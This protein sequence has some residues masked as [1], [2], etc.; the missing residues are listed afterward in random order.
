MTRNL[1]RTGGTVLVA[2]I[3]TLML[4]SAFAMPAAAATT[5]ATTTV[6]AD[7]VDGSEYTETATINFE[8]TDDDNPS[9]GETVTIQLTKSNVAEGDIEIESAEIDDQSG[10]GGAV[11]GV[12]V[13][14]VRDGNIYTGITDTV[15]VNVTSVSGSDASSDSFDLNVTYTINPQAAENAGAS[16]YAGDSILEITGDTV[17]DTNDN[18]AGN[19]IVDLDIE[20]GAADRLTTSGTSDFTHV[21][22]DTV[23]ITAVD[24]YGAEIV[25]GNINDDDLANA[26]TTYQD[27]TGIEAN[28]TSTPN[29]L[30]DFN[31]TVD[32]N[33]SSDNSG[34]GTYSLQYGSG[35][36]DIDTGN[37]VGNFELQVD[38]DGL[39]SSTADSVTIEPSAVVTTFEKSNYDADA[40]SNETNLSVE[41]TD[42]AGTNLDVA[43]L[44]V[45]LTASVSSAGNYRGGTANGTLSG[46]ALDS[47]QVVDDS[48][49]T[50]VIFTEN[51]NSSTTAFVFESTDAADY[52]ITATEPS[53][54]NSGSDTVTVNPGS[55]HTLDLSANDV[56]FDNGASFDDYTVTVEDA[57]DNQVDETSQ[58]SSSDTG[59]TFTLTNS[60]G[61]TYG[62][63]QGTL[64]GASGSPVTIG[65][66]SD[67]QA[68]VGSF[69][70]EVEQD[71]GQLENDIA[72]DTFTV[73]PAAV[74]IS[75][76]S[77]HDA[78]TNTSL[79][80]ALQ[81]AGTDG[82]V[83][84]VSNFDFDLR[85]NTENLQSGADIAG[86]EDL[87]VEIEDEGQLNA[88]GS[89]QDVTVTATSGTTEVIF[90]S[91]AAGAFQLQA[92]AATESG[93]A[94]DTSAEF[95]VYP[96]AISELSADISEEVIG[97][98]ADDGGNADVTVTLEDE[99]GNAAGY[100]TNAQ[101]TDV[102]ITLD[103]SGTEV[104]TQTISSGNL[105]GT[106]PEDALRTVSL[107]DDASTSALD[108]DSDITDTDVGEAT[109]NVDNADAN[110]V[111]TDSNL[112]IAHETYDLSEGFQRISLPQ[113]AEVATQ[114]VN[115]VTTWNTSAAT[116]DQDEI[117]VLTEQVVAGDTE[118][119][120]GLYVNA[121]NSN[122]RIGF[123][124]ETS[125]Q[126]NVGQE[127]LE[128]GWNLVGTNFDISTQ[129]NIP[130]EEDL[131]TV[132]EISNDPSSSEVVYDGGLAD[133]LDASGT[134]DNTETLDETYG[135]RAGQFGTYWV[136]VEDPSDL[137]SAE[138]QLIGSSYDPDQREDLSP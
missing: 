110:T 56:T 118:L 127:S 16:D 108:P 121:E 104:Y 44:S 72:T 136:Y 64:T 75:G 61:D 35:G 94:T 19:S 119:H 78:D 26:D 80:V 98:Q 68:G 120:S 71:S 123:D 25:P 31:T 125:E 86:S 9:V 23:T 117:D 109:L 8:G 95:D 81:D 59:L 126:V 39:V 29:G 134:G 131:R 48:L 124:F 4:L 87:K 66:S 77:N 7:E 1:K 14:E 18:L 27:I 34:T 106:N 28:L 84:N 43:E 93:S 40:T 99:F 2:L 89:Q 57:Y 111:A 76:A 38:S 20:P 30:E 65:D 6:N 132:D 52:Q 97:A 133:I 112:H 115:H 70:L 67:I 116:Y 83:N 22:T 45:D 79:D 50:S 15:V 91:T 90:N 33:L 82:P 55:A 37:Y 42:G 122:A 41:F 46:G 49:D 32:L 24:Q 129:D 53:G 73:Y 107:G 88:S 51:A 13:Q 47:S 96:L 17:G 21:S 114:N 12:E 128:A 100:Q 103:A 54:S 113:P 135:P 58:Y 10:L 36:S 5:P 69:T 74:S 138:R 92:E 85:L 130:L 105:E 11:T 63:A 62:T 3:A 60:S 137:T 101:D 102:N